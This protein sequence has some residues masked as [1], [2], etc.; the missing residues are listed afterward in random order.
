MEAGAVSSERAGGRSVKGHGGR[1]PQGERGRGDEVRGGRS[2]GPRAAWKR[3]AQRIRVSQPASGPGADATL[4]GLA[5]VSTPVSS[6]SDIVVSRETLT[7]VRRGKRRGLGTLR[8][9]P[10]A[11]G[12]NET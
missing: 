1:C 7:S 8:M 4:L 5:G 3:V 9:I 2:R 10:V 12:L 11:D 6:R